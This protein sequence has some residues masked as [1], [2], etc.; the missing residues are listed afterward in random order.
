MTYGN[1]NKNILQRWGNGP[2]LYHSRAG[3]GG[4]EFPQKHLEIHKHYCRSRLF[5]WRP[6]KCP[7]PPKIAAGLHPASRYPVNNSSSLSHVSAQLAEAFDHICRSRRS[8][9]PL[10]SHETFAKPRSLIGSRCFSYL[11]AS[12]IRQTRTGSARH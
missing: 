1:N 9:A 4:G 2:L 7:P 11:S 12:G 3:G 6:K 10:A 8:V 5:Q